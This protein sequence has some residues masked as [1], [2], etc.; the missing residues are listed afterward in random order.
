MS[1]SELFDTDLS[2]PSILTQLA[3]QTLTS[4]QPQS[5]SNLA[6][7]PTTSFL[8]G[9]L[10]LTI[11]ARRAWRYYLRAS[12][13]FPSSPQDVH[14]YHLH[15]GGPWPWI[16]ITMRE[17]SER[18]EEVNT[19]LVRLRML[20]ISDAESSLGIQVARTRPT[21][22]SAGFSLGQGSRSGYLD[23]VERWKIIME[24]E[25]RMM[26]IQETILDLSLEMHHI[27]GSTPTTTPLVPSIQGKTTIDAA[28]PIFG[29]SPNPLASIRRVL[30]NCNNNHVG[31]LRRIIKC[32]RKMMELRKEIHI[33]E[34]KSRREQIRWSLQILKLRRASTV[35]LY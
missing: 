31:R 28:Q 33:T 22:S 6:W 10:V 26:R 25:E 4:Q 7:S 2:L 3:E 21:S 30:L 5:G 24:Y 17:L 29:F 13:T 1:A 9:V 27:Q 11:C 8:V 32:Y 12:N 35:E 19:E 23:M 16:C 18:A 14:C 20:T 34:Q 15:E